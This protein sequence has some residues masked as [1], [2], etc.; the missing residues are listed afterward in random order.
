MPVYFNEKTKNITANFTIKIGK[1]YADKR[2]KRAFRLFVML[3]LM[4]K[5]F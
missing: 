1:V 3:K 5:I 4:N 2:K